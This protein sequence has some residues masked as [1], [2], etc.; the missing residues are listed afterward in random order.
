MAPLPPPSSCRQITAGCQ[1][2]THAARARC[3]AAQEGDAGPAALPKENPDIFSES[4]RQPWMSG[5]SDPAGGI[6]LVGG[7][8]VG[9]DPVSRCLS[10]LG[11]GEKGWL[12]EPCGERSRGSDG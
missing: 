6:G 3:L 12:R 8:V 2:E 5:E 10:R 11:G 9:A 1:S 4:S 7:A